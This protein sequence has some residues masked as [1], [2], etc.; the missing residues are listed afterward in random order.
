MVRNSEKIAAV[1]CAAW[2]AFDNISDSV[3]LYPP[4]KTAGYI[5]S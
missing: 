3:M 2:I 4:A 1:A 5:S